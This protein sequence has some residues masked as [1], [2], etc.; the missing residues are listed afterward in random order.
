M[1][2]V[3]LSLFVFWF[4]GSFAQYVAPVY[5]PAGGFHVD[6]NLQANSP[7]AGY[8]D[9]IPG[10]AGGGGF[11]MNAAG[12]PLDT[13]TT[14][15]IVDPY[16]SNDDV[17]SAGHFN[18][19]PN[20]Q[21]TWATGSAN[22]KTD[23]N[24]VLLH[25]TK[26][27]VGCHKWVMFSADRFGNAG[28]AYIDFEFLQ[29]TLTRTGATSGT[30]SSSGPNGGRT[31]N[32]LLFTIGYTGA[33]PASLVFYK[34]AQVSPGVY[35]YVQFTPSAGSAYGFTNVG[36]EAVPYNAFGITTYALSDQ[37]AEGAVDLDAVVMSIITQI[38][39]VIF[40]T[41]MIKSKVSTAPSASIGD[42]IAPIQLN[43][44]SINCI[45]GINEINLS[46][47][48]SIMPNPAN[49]KL[50]ISLDEQSSFV[51][52]QLEVYS[53]TGEKVF[54]S[55]FK[56]SR[57]QTFNISGLAPGIYS[58]YVVTDKGIAVKKMVKQ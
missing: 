43:N 10:P 1:K 52:A 16:N 8:G 26:D 9:W 38:D 49:D 51:N 39:S 5:P 12:V 45:V 54:E 20:T 32:D 3:L 40:K 35:D 4:T 21:W 42:I 53:L 56:N 22:N 25:F 50:T 23:L 41:L 44:L 58:V 37:F 7:T 46:S 27:S 6:G 28:T 36:G 33:G 55:S 31:V 57:Q 13:T 30:Y 24:N 17:Q 29:N 2:K 15:H 14:F 11:V 34:W 48:V 19:N 47:Q 18:E